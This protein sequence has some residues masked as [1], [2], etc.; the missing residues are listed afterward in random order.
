[1]LSL[2]HLLEIQCMTCFVTGTRLQC[3]VQLTAVETTRNTEGINCGS[4]PSYLNHEF[5]SLSPVLINLQCE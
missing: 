1:M 2:P 3:G 4:D 5:V